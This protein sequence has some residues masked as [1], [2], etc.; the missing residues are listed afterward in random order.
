MTT[1]PRYRRGVPKRPRIRVL[2]VAAGAE[3]L[4]LALL[5]VLYFTR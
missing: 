1:Q 5:E 3:L 4:A 2:L